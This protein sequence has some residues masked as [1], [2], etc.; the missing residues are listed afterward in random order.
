M[1][2]NINSFFDMLTHGG[3]FIALLY[4]AMKVPQEHNSSRVAKV[5]GAFLS[6]FLCLTCMQYGKTITHKVI[7]TTWE[8]VILVNFIIVSLTIYKHDQGV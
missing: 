8:F 4:L 3:T 7:H 5:I 6:L 2:S 1:T